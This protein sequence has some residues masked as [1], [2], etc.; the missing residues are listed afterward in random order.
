MDQTT[1]P[2]RPQKLETPETRE[3]T[4]DPRLR[5]YAER[6]GAGEVRAT[7]LRRE[8]GGPLWLDDDG[9]APAALPPGA[10]SAVF[11]RY[12]RPLSVEVRA[13]LN[14]AQAQ[15]AAPLWLEPDGGG[16]L[17]FQFRP[18]GWVQPLDYLLWTPRSV[19]DRRRAAADPATSRALDP[20]DEAEPLAAPAPLIGAALRALAKALAR[21]L[22]QP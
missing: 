15:E 12:G 2:A 18:L 17:A 9:A 5:L 8:A 14:E 10:I 21:S 7:W 16:L 13:Q 1:P 22:A 20:A 19:I 3:E 6:D 11:L 4:Q